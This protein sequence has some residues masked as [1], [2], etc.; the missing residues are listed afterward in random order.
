[1]GTTLA[2]RQGGGEG[3]FLV[4]KV[5]SE[6][7][8]CLGLPHRLLAGKQ[9][10]PLLLPVNRRATQL[11]SRSALQPSN[12]QAQTKS[13]PTAKN[14]AATTCV[15]KAASTRMPFTNLGGFDLNDYAKVHIISF[16][17]LSPC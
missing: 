3:R 11:A 13:M 10:P 5:S 1:M 17:Q 6:H 9:P 15:G 14:M 16:P 4:Q 2:W 12:N 8:S 7:H